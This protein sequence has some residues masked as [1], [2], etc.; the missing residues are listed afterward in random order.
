MMEASELWRL[1][2]GVGVDRLYFLPLSPAPRV[3]C[4]SLSLSWSRETHS[5]WDAK[6]FMYHFPDGVYI[7]ETKKRVPSFTR[8]LIGDSADAMFLMCLTHSFLITAL[9]G[10]CY[11]HCLGWRKSRPGFLLWNCPRKKA[12]KGL[13]LLIPLM[14]TFLAWVPQR[15][16]RGKWIP[17]NHVQ[18]YLHAVSAF[19]RRQS[20]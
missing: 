20:P 6:V 4:P 5:L 14:Q 8:C 9:S 18:R 13:G 3:L 17:W 11:Y 19:F 7:L 2:E 12:M 16:L 15:D 1:Q 10:K